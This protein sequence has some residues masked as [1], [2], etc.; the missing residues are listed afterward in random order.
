MAENTKKP[1][2][3]N[4]IQVEDQGKPLDIRDLVTDESESLA[5]YLSVSVSNNGQ[6]TTISATSPGSDPQVTQTVITGMTATDLQ[7]LIKGFGPD[8]T[9][10][11]VI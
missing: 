10:I 2:E 9:D 4:Q 6:D 1:E 7:D 8:I 11:D 5:E 3:I